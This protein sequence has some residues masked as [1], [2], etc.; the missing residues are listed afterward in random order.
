MLAVTVVA[1]TGIEADALST[2][3]YVLGA[4]E[5]LRLLE[6]RGADGLVLLRE[7]GRRVL[8]ATPGFATRYHLVAAAGIEVTE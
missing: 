5:G 7:G 2:A 3:V 8:R 6:R 4:D 1:A